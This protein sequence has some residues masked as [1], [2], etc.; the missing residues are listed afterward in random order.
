MKTV[1]QNFIDSLKN[2]AP[3]WTRT[4]YYKRR[5]WNAAAGV[6]AYESSW[7]AL[8]ESEVASVSQISW[9][10]DSDR[11]N[12]FK[13][14]SL[15]LILRNFDQKWRGENRSGVFGPD[16]ASP[17][18]YEPHKMKFQVRISL[19]LY[20]DTQEEIT[21]YTGYA[22]EYNS[23]SEQGTIEIAL[24][25][26]ETLL[27]NSN[28]ENVSTAVVNE[29]LG[30]GNGS[31][32]A[33]VTAHT[34]VGI[35]QEVSINGIA[36]R[37]GVDYTVSGLNTTG[38]AAT[39][40]F[41]V[42]PVAASALRVSYLYWKVSQQ[43]ETLVDLL[44]DE[45]GIL[46]ADKSI[47]PVVFPTSIINTRTFQSNAEW[48]TGDE[49]GNTDDTTLLNA[50][51]FNY[52]TTQTWNTS[53]SG[54]TTVLTG[55]AAFANSGGNNVL[56]GNIGNTAIAYRAS[57]T[58]IGEWVVP[59]KLSQTGTSNP[60]LNIFFMAGAYGSYSG[61][62]GFANSYCALVEPGSSMIVLLW[63]DSTNHT[64]FLGTAFVSVPY[65]TNHVLRI[66]R[67]GNGTIT[68]FLNGTQ[69]LQIV[70]TNVTSATNFAY[71]VSSSGLTSNTFTLTLS[72]SSTFGVPSSTTGVGYWVSPTIDFGA[73]PT[74]WGSFL[75][76]QTL[77]GGAVSYETQSSA[78]GVSWD[79][80]VAV[81]GS[82]VGSTLRRYFRVKIT[83]DI[84]NGDPYVSL[85]SVSSLTASTVV[86]LAN[87]TGLTVYDAVAALAQFADYE[88]GFTSDEQFFFRPKATT[89]TP[90]LEASRSDFILAVPSVLPGNDRVYSAVRAEYGNYISD[91]VDGG[92]SVGSSGAKIDFNRLVL[93]GGN[94]LI[95]SDAD[96]AT[97]VARAF[98]VRYSKPRKRVKLITK[99]I[100]HV[101][102]SDTIEATYDDNRP[103]GW[104]IGDTS[105]RLGDTSLQ[106]YGGDQ[107]TLYGF[108]GKV[109][110]LRFDIDAWQSEV[111]LEE[112]L[113]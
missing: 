84:T 108:I 79:S 16:S 2:P 75:Y 48:Q 78:D 27:V 83:I 17:Q 29:S 67:N 107:Q 72:G 81:S 96:V 90:D 71:E 43:I 73:T 57:T 44:T 56:S 80:Y 33:Y 32:T 45:A 100:P 15:T 28:A 98:L 46:D 20:D 11:L 12:Q 68:L 106:L 101:E 64:F 93:S 24:A 104:Y 51:Q 22:T 69:I 26:P 59:F 74:S 36:K 77:A 111:D 1:T 4:I 53:T 88:F 55:S 50:L 7:T 82:V 60:N 42:A 19:K 8:S 89:G 91:A 38:V 110:G 58:V 112:I 31:T 87:F 6:Y 95:S 10:L 25:G 61:G 23:N 18:G 13:V 5:Y 52:T 41:A 99:L 66:R 76:T 70:D 35:V 3:D 113:Q 86:S 49:S 37:A 9:Q 102:L 97:G 14:S 105:K 62:A 109:I 65:N 39:I 21:V 92:D 63:K 34:G 47:S 85:L 103:K 30:T 94:I 40:T 54:W